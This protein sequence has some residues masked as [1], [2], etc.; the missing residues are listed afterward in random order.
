MKLTERQEKLY[1]IIYTRDFDFSAAE[2]E[3]SSGI[4]TPEDVSVVGCAYVYHCAFDYNHEQD[5]DWI[6][7]EFHDGLESSHMPKTIELLLQ[8]GLDPNMIIGEENIMRNLQFVSNGYVSADALNL[9]LENGGNPELCINDEGIFEEIYF[10]IVFDL[11][12]QEIR[13]R[14][15]SLM[16]FWMVLEGHRAERGEFDSPVKANRN[17]DLRNLKNHRN[18]YYGAVPGNEYPNEPDLVIFDREYNIEVAR[19]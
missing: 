18:Y 1:S 12:E 6:P 3:L 16:H 7:G 19:Y 5:L 11:I 4:Y 9:L 14:Y 2:Q 13:S 17:F 15:D 10:N 8:Y